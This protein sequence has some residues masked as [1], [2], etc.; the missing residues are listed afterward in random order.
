MIRGKHFNCKKHT[1]TYMSC[2][3]FVLKD[4]QNNVLDWVEDSSRGGG[5]GGGPLVMPAWIEGGANKTMILY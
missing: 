4:R 1:R 3:H 2:L 5:A